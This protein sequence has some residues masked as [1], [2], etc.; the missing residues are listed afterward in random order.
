MLACE[1]NF[2]RLS[3]I[4]QLLLCRIAAA[5]ASDCSS[6]QDLYMASGYLAQIAPMPRK[7]PL[8][9]QACMSPRM[10]RYTAL[11]VPLRS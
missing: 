8:Y 5:M 4:K 1:H 11:K 7:I 6:A 2:S 3:H 9:T 10:G